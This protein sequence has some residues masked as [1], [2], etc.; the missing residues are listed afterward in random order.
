[1]GN[2]LP[3]S[4]TDKLPATGVN[5]A[6]DSS[7]HSPLDSEKEKYEVL[8]LQQELRHNRV[9]LW[10]TLIGAFAVLLGLALDRLKTLE[11]RRILAANDLIQ[12]Q[13]EAQKTLDQRDYQGGKDR[14]QRTYDT[15]RV[16]D[17]HDYEGMKE[18]DQRNYELQTQIQNERIARMTRVAGEFDQL[19]TET[20][21]TLHR[22]LTKV[23]M[24]SGNFEGLSESL[25]SLKRDSDEIRE[26]QRYV[27]KVSKE[28]SENPISFDQFSDA[29]ALQ[30]KW[31]S[32]PDSLTPDFGVVFS[33]SLAARWP[34]VSKAA[35][36][37]L[38]RKFNVMSSRSIP[39][40]DD[41]TGSL[42]RAA[43]QFQSRMR[44]E[45]IDQRRREPLERSAKMKK[46]K[47]K[48]SQ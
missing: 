41:L 37:A 30:E 34:E 45:I 10:F 26:V 19:Y 15:Q 28:L 20:L 17:Q 47:S 6:T 36:D 23:V 40:V 27:E 29:A 1:M 18:S 5:N 13:Y 22:D 31:A 2:D 32:K 8:K 35:W 24:L 11:D 25:K 48:T 43:G 33:R 14:E 44:K 7:Q 21:E 3:E 16:L 4:Q 46:G 39:D 12:R 38:N 9:K 42:R